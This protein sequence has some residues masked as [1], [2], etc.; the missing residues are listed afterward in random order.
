VRFP[1]LQSQRVNARPV[2]L[3]GPPSLGFH[4][5]SRCQLAESTLA[6]VPSPLRSV[7][8]V[9][10]VPDGFLLHQP[11][12]VYFTP[13][14]RPGFALQGVFLA[15]SRTSSSP[16]VALLSLPDAPARSFI[17]WLQNAA[18][19]YRAFLRSRIRRRTRWFR[20]RSCS[21]PS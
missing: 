17:Q 9:S 6:G 4:P 19:A 7:L 14:P 3:S 16:A 13:Q 5:S 2:L 21:I 12:R 15:R 1:S 10:H 11:L 20:P 18:P 8:D